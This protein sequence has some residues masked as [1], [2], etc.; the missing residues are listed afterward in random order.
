M[1]NNRQDASSNH[2]A[3][4]A[5]LEQSLRAPIALAYA[6]A[7]AAAEPNLTEAE[8]I[9]AM[10]VLVGIC[11][12]ARQILRN[13]NL[14]GKL[15]RAEPIEL[16]LVRLGAR[17]C[18]AAL[19][20]AAEE[21]AVLVGR[22]RKISISIDEASFGRLDHRPVLAD[23]DLIEQS[24]RALADNSVRY[25]YPNSNIDIQGGWTTDGAFSIAFRNRGIPISEKDVK[26]ISEYGWRGETAR[27]S[28]GEGSGIGLWLVNNIIKAH[29]DRL[30]V[31]P[32]SPTGL[33]E[34]DIVI[35]TE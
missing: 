27:L 33:T 7:R 8:R 26:R 2:L 14:L 9:E 6:R 24:F 1:N 17:D 35:P 15:H 30:R 18:V 20:N 22:H 32:T 12:R 5:D 11:G 31:C 34:V 10:R 3:V 28:S 19:S 25:S 23:I 13:I 29:K 21:A 16:N 4:L